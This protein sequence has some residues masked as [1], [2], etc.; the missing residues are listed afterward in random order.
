MTSVGGPAFAQS[1]I[2]DAALSNSHWYVPVP[3]LLAYAAPATGFSNPIAIGDQTLWSLGTATNGAFT[4][5]SSAQLAIGPAAHTENSTIQGFVT[6]SGQITMVFTP[7]GG[8]TPTVGLGQ[9]RLID[10]VWQMEMQMITG[11]NLLITHWAYMTPYNPATFS[12]PAPQPIL[13]NSVPEWAWTSGTRWRI[14]SPS[15]FGTATP[16]RFVMSN[17]QNGYF[18]GSG[19]AP[20]ASSAGN[21]TL[22]GS[23]TPEGRVLFNT[24]SRGNLTSLYGSASGDP[25]GAQMLVSTYDLTGS[26]T[27]GWAAM[28]LVQPYAEVLAGQNNRAGLGAADV[29]DRMASTPLG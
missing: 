23:V 2:W 7:V 18:W 10:G 24:L 26:P 13:A 8:G 9:M 22:L 21:F 5:F 20:S 27:G 17:Y 15:M 1:A 25:S 12:P 19:A 6:T 29:L 16:G 11:Q 4:G 3:Q 14:A 28:S